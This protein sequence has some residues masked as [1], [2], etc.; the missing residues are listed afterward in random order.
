MLTKTLFSTIYYSIQ[1]IIGTVYGGIVMLII[2][3]V[4]GF[5]LSLVENIRDYRKPL[6]ET[7]ITITFFSFISFISYDV[8]YGEYD[9]LVLYYCCTIIM[10]CG[11]LLL[12]GFLWGLTNHFIFAIGETTEQQ[13]HNETVLTDY[14]NNNN[15]VTTGVQFN[16]L[17]DEY[18]EE[19]IVEDDDEVDLCI[20]C[21]ERKIRTTVVPC[22]HQLSCVTCSRKLTKRQCP[23]CNKTFVAII[24]NYS[25]AEKSKKKSK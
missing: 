18:E 15:I 21:D 14:N 12:V 7:I 1:C 20:C 4:F 6:I 25:C 22:G 19:T 10:G 13:S 3:I 8:M 24:R 2:A 5:I 16:I 23:I 17:P 11:L 9:S